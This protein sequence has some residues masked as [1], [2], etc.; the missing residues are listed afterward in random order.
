M[1]CFL[2]SCTVVPGTETLNP[3]NHFIDEMRRCFPENCRALF[4]CSD[5]DG[6][7]TTDFFA[8]STKKGFDGAGFLFRRYIVLD[9][10]NEQEAASLIR[11]SDFIMLAGGHVPTQ[12]RFFERIG[13]RKLIQGFP[14]VIVGISAGTMNAADVVYAQ[15]EAAG[16]AVDP[17]YKKFL[18]GLNLTKTML[19]PHYQ[20]V[21]N[22]VLD[23]LRLFED[24]TCPDSRGRT[25]YAIPDGSYL[26]IANGREELRGEAY[27]V[28]DGR[29][30]RIA[31]E[32]DVL[33]M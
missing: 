11:G 21:R 1:I 32:G 3:A 25:F 15:P 9:G 6:H 16:E 18:T 12:N 8:N 23:G 19:L 31:D 22:D 2:T 5:P 33:K 27:A 13:L 26:Y 24:I 4:I 20:L 14:G 7:G 30:S 17:G 29:I 28:S 10:R